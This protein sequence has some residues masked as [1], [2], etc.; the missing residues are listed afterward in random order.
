LAALRLSRKARKDLA[1]LVAI[2]LGLGLFAEVL[3]NASTFLYALVFGVALVYWWKAA[4]DDRAAS[5][6]RMV[7]S[8]LKVSEQQLHAWGL[9]EDAVER[10]L[11]DASRR[12]EYLAVLEE[13]GEETAM[14]IEELLRSQLTRAQYDSL[15]AQAARHLAD[16]PAREER[17]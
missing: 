12:A 16:D 8:V 2:V 7:K 3:G 10:L 5:R 14:R 11:C 15:M 9:D 1:G 6:E 4:T 17:G 13:E